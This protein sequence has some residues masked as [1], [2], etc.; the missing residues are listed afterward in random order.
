MSTLPASRQPHYWLSISDSLSLFFP[1]PNH[2]HQSS[3]LDIILLCLCIS[4]FG[5]LVY[6]KSF[7]S[8]PSFSITYPK[9]LTLL[10]SLSVLSKCNISKIVFTLCL[11]P[12]FSSF[13]DFF[14]HYTATLLSS[15]FKTAIFFNFF[16]N[17][18]Y[19]HR[20]RQFLLWKN[21]PSF[22][23]TRLQ[24]PL[25]HFRLSPALFLSKFSLKITLSGSLCF[26][27]WYMV[28]FH[29]RFKFFYNLV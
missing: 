24:L 8:S 12:W 7:Q 4:S 27:R 15:R 5:N 22:T 18:S 1:I 6:S 13:P 16:L 3:V 28:E 14:F 20:T 17:Y 21:N 11:S 29:C 23:S 19:L 9:S 2:T 25:P 26:I 10:G